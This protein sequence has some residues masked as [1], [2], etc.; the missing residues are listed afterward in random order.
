MAPI[1][2][3]RM[4]KGCR[5]I[6]GERRLRAC[7]ELGLPTIPARILDMEGIREGNS[8]YFHIRM[9]HSPYLPVL[10]QTG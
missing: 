5:L 8:P 1:I 9:I 2:L 6:A 7:R 3:M 10:R 4:E